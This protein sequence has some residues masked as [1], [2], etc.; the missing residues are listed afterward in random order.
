MFFDGIY[1]PTITH[2]YIPVAEEPNSPPQAPPYIY[3][4]G[5]STYGMKFDL[6][7]F[8]SACNI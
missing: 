6:K 2:T 4:E 1:T 7:E 8:V 3:N 5:A